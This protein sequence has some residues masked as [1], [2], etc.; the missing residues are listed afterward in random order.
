MFNGGDKKLAKLHKFP[1]VADNVRVK[2]AKVTHVYDDKR[3]DAELLAKACGIPNVVSR[4]EDVIGKVDAVM[5]PDDCSMAHQKRA[6]VFLKEKIP[7]FVD[8]PLSP[9]PRE[10]EAI[11]GLA[12]KHKALFMSSSALRFAREIEDFNRKDRAAIG[13]IITGN[14]LGP[15][16]LVFYGIH[17]LEALITLA[18]PGVRSVRNA[19]GIYRDVLS[20]EYK[21]GR[22]FTLTVNKEMNYIFQVNLYGTKGWRQVT[23][24]DSAYFYS[25]MLKHFVRMVR[26]GREPFSPD[27]TLEIIRI[28]AAGAKL[29]N[30]AK[31]ITI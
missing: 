3:A 28:L 7:T 25:N 24:S 26:T 31:K 23:I 18:G 19:G 30:T 14:A 16:E 21:N 11:I 10:A 15:N 22:L 12:R 6:A 2:G 29:R 1:A 20:L 9:D 4:Q 17:A 13:D 8:K 27:E 5:I